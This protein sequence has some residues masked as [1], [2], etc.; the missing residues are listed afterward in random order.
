MFKSVL[1]T[2]IR[3]Y[4]RDKATFLITVIG[5]SVGIGAALLIFIYLYNE[6]SFESGFPNSSRIYRLAVTSQVDNKAT[7]F[8]T[9]IPAL[10]PALKAAIPEI[11]KLVRFTNDHAVAYLKTPEANANITA[12]NLLTAEPSFF[13]IF[14][15]KFI[16]GS[17]QRMN[18]PYQIV[19]TEELAKRLFGRTDVTGQSVI[20]N[21]NTTNLFRVAGVIK[22]PP[23]NTHLQFDGIFSWSTFLKEEKVWDDAFAYT[24]FMISRQSNISDIKRKIDEFVNSNKNIAEVEKSLNTKAVMDV[25]PIRDIHLYSHRFNE[26]SE[27]NT[28][29]ILYT[30]MTVGFFFLLCTIVNYTNLSIAGSLRRM[31]EIG[32]RKVM[33]SSAG[34]IR[35][36]FFWESF[37]VTGFSVLLSILISILC[38]RAFAGLINPSLSLGIF[39]DGKFLLA[40]GLFSLIITLISGSYPSIYLSRF[41]PIEIFRKKGINLKGGYLPVRKVLMVVQL[42]IATCVIACTLI[43]VSQIKYI[44]KTDVGFDRKNIVSLS[45]PA[46]KAIDYFKD[47]FRKYPGVVSEAASNYSPHSPANDE[48]SIEQEGGQMAIFNVDRMTCDYAFVGLMGM[49]VLKGR[50][51]DTAFGSDRSSAFLV[52]SAFA[53]YFGWKDPIGKRIRSVHY[54]KSGT[55]VGMVV[56]ASLY[57]LHHKNAPMLIDLSSENYSSGEGLFIKYDTRNVSGLI[58]K[59]QASYKGV[60]GDLP[61]EYSFLDE[62]YDRL[63]KSDERFARVMKFGVVIMLVISCLG[64]YGLSNFITSARKSEIGIRKVLGAS[65]TQITYL[66]LRD[67]GNLALMGALIAVPISY[68][69]SWRWLQTF[70]K[71]VPIGAWVFIGAAVATILS[72]TITI[73][74][75]AIRLSRVKPVDTIREQ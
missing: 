68:Y 72:V 24:Y 25:Q 35:A 3:S 57:S 29:G 51:F 11:E 31:K 47:E 66:H 19:L 52:N 61:M 13:D 45:V 7:E 73:S 62:A 40:L 63:Y 12:R 2:A 15:F 59:M 30:F 37:A 46:P 54:D 74:Y 16:D 21:T 10:G 75:H 18:E 44:I 36:Q 55:V 50:N 23:A 9:T 6:Y 60:F 38:F 20:L 65:I 5:F 27:G 33:G 56:D 64:L 41:D 32:V 49:K 34:Q 67:F 22:T 39:Q 14:D 69:A 58:E 48:F 42:A 70:T 4:F 1:K 71:R 8:A 43:V 26:L 17:A 53:D 28:P